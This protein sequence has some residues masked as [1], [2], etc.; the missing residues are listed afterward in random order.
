MMTMMTTDGPSGGRLGDQREEDPWQA[1]AQS[2][3]PA[4][5]RAAA[6]DVL[7]VFLRLGLTSFGGPI[8]HIGYFRDAFV[9]RRRWLSEQAYADLVA[10]CQFLPGP[11]SSQTGFAIGLMHAGYLGGLAAW[12]GFTL[13]SAMLMLLFAA[14][15]GSLGGVLGRGMLH[16]LKLVAVAIVAQAVWGMA[17]ALCPDRERASIA[18]VAALLVLFS[19]SSVVQIAAILLGGAAGLFLCRDAPP[20][21]GGH[22]AMPVSRR[23]GIVALVAFFVFLL[24]ALLLPGRL[25]LRGFDLFAAFYRSG[26]LVFGGGHVVLPLL[27]EAFVA[28][29]WVSDDAFLAGYGAAQA[30]PGPLFTFAAYL[31]AVSNLDPNG[32][33]GAVLGLIGI[34]LPGILVLIGMLPFWDAFRM[35]LEAQAA[36]RGVNAAVVGILGAALYNPVWTSSVKAPSDL[37]IALVGFVLLVAW[38]A[39][40]LVVVVVSALGGLALAKGQ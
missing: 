29:G 24:A 21:T 19:A 1:L 6:L 4:P 33:A 30:V 16:G 9:A 17:R 31:G 5:K 36:M 26:A 34:F 40:P 27:R 10:L 11:A 32:V 22:V 12:I 20:L 38:R 8:A 39:P 13:P 3:Q 23:A 2:P 7:L 25:S 28:P 18:A 37:A 14:G 15:V 35:R